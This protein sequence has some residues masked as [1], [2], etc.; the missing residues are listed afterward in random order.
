MCVL[1]SLLWAAS[2]G[3]LMP[4]LAACHRSSRCVIYINYYYYYSLL[5]PIRQHT[6]FCYRTWL[7]NSLSL[8]SQGQ[9]LSQAFSTN[10]FMLKL[11]YRMLKCNCPVAWYTQQEA[12]LSSRDRAMRR[13]N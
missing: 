9:E 7:L 4:P 10:D 1:C 5:R 13:V 12:Q 2:Y 6:Y 11:I 3:G 8:Q